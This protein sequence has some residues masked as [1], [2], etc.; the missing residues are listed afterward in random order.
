VCQPVFL[1]FFAVGR[2]I[3]SLRSLLQYC[4][5]AS[6]PVL[7]TVFLPVSVS[8]KNP[9]K[10][11]AWRASCVSML[12]STNRQV[13]PSADPRQDYFVLV[14]TLIVF[15]SRVTLKCLSFV[16]V[17]FIYLRKKPLIIVLT[18]AVCASVYAVQ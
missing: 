1:T 18:A 4:L 6:V 2:L 16:V 14:S 11:L 5:Y 7:S 10:L 13:P 15:G 12:A 3:Q 9:P 17:I 8:I